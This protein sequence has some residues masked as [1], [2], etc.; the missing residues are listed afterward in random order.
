MLVIRREQFE[1]LRLQREIDTAI[2]HVRKFFPLEADAMSYR[3]LREHIEKALISARRYGLG[4]A[5]RISYVDFTLLFG[6]NF[7]AQHKWAKDI[8]TVADPARARFRGSNLF[9]RASIELKRRER[10]EAIDG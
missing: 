9:R 6:L 1:A 4:Q 5:D 8:L 7:D 10:S 2:L 3:E